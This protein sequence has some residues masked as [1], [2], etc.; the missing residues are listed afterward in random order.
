MRNKDAL[1]L[2]AKSDGLETCGLLL[3]KRNYNIN[4]RLQYL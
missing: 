4:N 1:P 2:H 3:I